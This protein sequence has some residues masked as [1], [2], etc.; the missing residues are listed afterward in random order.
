MDYCKPKKSCKMKDHCHP[1]HC[2]CKVVRK[3]IEAQ[4][5]IKRACCD[6]SCFS[7]IQQL[8]QKRQ[9]PLNKHTTIPFLLYCIGNCKP[10]IGKGFCKKYSHHYHD[11]IFEEIESPFFRAK[12]IVGSKCCVNLEL[13]IPIKNEKSPQDFATYVC[14]D[15]YKDKLINNFVASGV[16]LTVDLDHFIG[17]TCLDPITPLSPDCFLAN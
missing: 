13:L 6:S 4:D 1:E 16:C 7:S 11:K 14:D 3:I 9:K 5:Q 8:K 17:I 15:R 2:V 10:F 12:K